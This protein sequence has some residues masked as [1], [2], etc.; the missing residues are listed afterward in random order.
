MEGGHMTLGD[1]DSAP[2]EEVVIDEAANE[3]VVAPNLRWE[4]RDSYVDEGV[5]A[6]VILLSTS[7]SELKDLRDKLICLEVTHEEQADVN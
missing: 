1:D 7:I 3:E 4:F 2:I 5:E 6:R